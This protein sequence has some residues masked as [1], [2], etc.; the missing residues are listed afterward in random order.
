MATNKEKIMEGVRYLA[1]AFPFILAG[2]SVYFWA[3]VP[4]MAEGNYWWAIGAGA[5]MGV[6]VFL[7]VKG[8]R[9]VLAGLF[10]S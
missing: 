3:G 4:A 2:P 7:G 5:L 6:A 9:T 1:L 10:N 8:L